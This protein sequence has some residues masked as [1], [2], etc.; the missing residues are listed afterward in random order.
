MDT[1]KLEQIEDKFRKVYYEYFTDYLLFSSQYEDLIENE[2]L[3]EFIYSDYIEYLY[4][5]CKELEGNNIYPKDIILKFIH[6]VSLLEKRIEQIMDESSKSIFQTKTQEILQYLYNEIDTD[7]KEIYYME[8]IKR[9][10]N[11]KD[12]SSLK[13]STIS[14]LVL[15]IQKDF[16]YLDIL[17]RDGVEKVDLIG[18]DF[19]FFLQKLLIDFPE[20]KDYP[21]MMKNL[22]DI[23]KAKN[24]KN[25]DSYLY[26]LRNAEDA[27]N[28]IGFNV[29]T[30]E[31]L[32]CNTLLQKM[33]FTGKTKEILKEIDPK[34]LFTIPF[35]QNLCDEF[36]IY[37]EKREISIQEKEAYQELVYFMRKHLKECSGAYKEAFNSVLNAWVLFFNSNPEIVNPYSIY[38]TSLKKSE[39]L[40]YFTVPLFFFKEQEFYTKA[41]V[42]MELAYDIMCYFFGKD[43]LEELKE[44]GIYTVSAL[45]YLYHEYPKMFFDPTVYQKTMLLLNSIQNK[46][47]KRLR[48]KIKK[49]RKE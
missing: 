24:D 8:Y 44:D 13:G 1:K 49:I 3:D 47:S 34:I 14:N 33:I 43:N 5:T 30:M 17:M 42:Q 2:S 19:S 12:I 23:I 35:F 7:E 4:E 22:E 6:F 10:S 45:T 39:D 32:Y 48:E 18:D 16:L 21:Y 15:D 11:M 25:L 20:I 29:N 40:N 26:F 9:Y 41:N 27:R 31:L 46:K 38:A 28:E 37:S 36:I